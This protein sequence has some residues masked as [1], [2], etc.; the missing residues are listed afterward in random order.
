MK[1]LIDTNVIL[2]ALMEREP[3]AKAAQNVMLAVAGEKT[4]GCVT[5]STITD[6]YYLLRKYL[7]D[8]EKTR[9]ALFGLLSV[10]TVLDVT[11]KDCEEAL[12]LPMT[13]YEDALL[14]YCAKRHKVDRI[15]TR[16][17][18]HF[19]GSPV[20]AIQPEEFIMKLV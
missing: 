17:V 10:I 7:R 2:D 3:W 12:R 8:K 16:N 18:K 13:D 19:D 14:A 1:A 9:Q 15:M 4:E 11:G 6:I 5:A 20:K